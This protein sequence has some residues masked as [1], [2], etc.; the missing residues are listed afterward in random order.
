MMPTSQSQISNH[1][2]SPSTDVSSSVPVSLAVSVPSSPMAIT[3]ADDST[4][5]ATNDNV[6]NGHTLLSSNVG[7]LH[8][9]HHH[10]Q[11]HSHGGVSSMSAGQSQQH[12][13]HPAYRIPGYMEQ[14]YAMQ[15]SSPSA[16]YHGN[17]I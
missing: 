12:D 15:R 5:T 7:G 17:F 9:H 4:V 3:V 13:F 2:A 14:F 1:I 11:F 8:H 16:S 6:A 10:H